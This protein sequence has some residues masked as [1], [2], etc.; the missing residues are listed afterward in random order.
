MRRAAA[1]AIASTTFSTM[2]GSLQPNLMPSERRLAREAKAA[3]YFE[4]K[5]RPFT[6]PGTPRP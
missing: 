2:Y 1:C 4:A 3:A 5:V 6:H